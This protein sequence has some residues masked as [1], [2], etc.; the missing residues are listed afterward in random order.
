MSMPP[1]SGERTASMQTAMGP[2][3]VYYGPPAQ[4]SHQ[5]PLYAHP[6]YQGR[7]GQVWQR[8]GGPHYSGGH[9]MASYPAPG[10]AHAHHASAAQAHARHGLVH[11]SIAPGRIPSHELGVAARVQS[12]GMPH[13]AMPGT[14]RGVHAVEVMGG[15]GAMAFSIPHSY[16]ASHA[17]PSQPPPH[18]LP[19]AATPDARQVRRPAA[20]AAPGVA[21]R[22]PKGGNP[23][24]GQPAPHPNPG[25]KGVSWNKS[26]GKWQAYSRRLGPGKG[27]KHLGYYDTIEQAA[28]AV[29]SS[30]AAAGLSPEP[31]RAPRGT[32]RARDKVVPEAHS[33]GMVHAMPVAK[34]AAVPSYPAHSSYVAGS[35]GGAWPA[36]SAPPPMHPQFS[37]PTHSGQSTDPVD[38]SGFGAPQVTSRHQTISWASSTAAMA[39]AGT[40]ALAQGRSTS[41]PT[42]SPLEA[43]AAAA[44]DLA[45]PAKPVP[46]LPGV[47]T[48]TARASSQTSGGGQVA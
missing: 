15:D 30:E 31:P 11:P 23:M 26:A 33:E 10:A 6:T 22:R 21:R 27:R 14:G 9:T 46:K 24:K 2:E 48:L 47:A 20:Q 4:A 12:G 39:A 38:G 3:G 32:K 41:L 1:M 36:A 16:P 13:D 42:A 43:L 18:T 17:L 19:A 28:E 8:P 35:G 5:Q 34:V 7:P 40:W 29:R 45:P 25:I 44:S 37:G